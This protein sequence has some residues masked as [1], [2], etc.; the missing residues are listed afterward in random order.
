MTSDT[1]NMNIK[2]Y[3]VMGQAGQDDS[4]GLLGLYN[5]L[6]LAVRA[7][8]DYVTTGCDGYYGCYIIE[9]NLN[10]TATRNS[11]VVFNIS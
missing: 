3:A 7:S 10:E 4:D 9:K 2:I 1:K 8:K 11:S 5:S 6:E